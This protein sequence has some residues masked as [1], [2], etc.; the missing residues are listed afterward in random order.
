ML[1]TAALCV[2]PLAAQVVDL[3]KPVE[4]AAK[5]EIWIRAAEADAKAAEE[6]ARKD[7]C[8]RL[9]EAVYRL[10]VA[11]NRDVF[12]MV[13]KN[14]AVTRDLIAGLSLAKVVHAD[15]LED[16]T[17]RVKVTTTPAAA[18]EILK[19]A[20]AKVDW[21]FQEDEGTIAAVARLTKA[22][23]VV[24]AEG[25]AALAGSLGEKRIPVRRAALV[26]A[27]EEIAG[28]ILVMVLGNV[29]E[30]GERVRDFLVGLPEAKRKL[31][32]GLAET[33]ICAE[34]W[35]DDGSLSLRAEL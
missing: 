32:L 21:E 4:Q 29:Y 3:D 24:Y 1:V 7:A 10:P 22:D 25:E 23:T 8:V 6:A 5:P 2:V 9:V 31:A 12:D 17:V 16:G 27:E 11:S 28:K 35:A 18:M 15:Y 33:R 20:Y 34:E 14:L 26:R 30:K 19:K 13:M